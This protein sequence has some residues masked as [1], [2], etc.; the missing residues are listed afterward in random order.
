ME[1]SF[2]IL[3]YDILDT[4]KVDLFSSVIR[5]LL[6]RLIVKSEIDLVYFYA[7]VFRFASRVSA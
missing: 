6:K 7:D 2:D 3:C 5:S 4:A 1:G